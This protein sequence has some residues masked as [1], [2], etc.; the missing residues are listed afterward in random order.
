[1]TRF[2][3]RLAELLKKNFASCGVNKTSINPGLPIVF[4]G[5]HSAAAIREDPEAFYTSA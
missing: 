2:I 1:M 4:I 5:N 3:V